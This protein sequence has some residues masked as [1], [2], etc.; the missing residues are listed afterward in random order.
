MII[1]PG[2]RATHLRLAAAERRPGIS[3][4][5]ANRRP[6]RV[7]STTPTIAATTARISSSLLLEGSFS[8]LLRSWPAQAK[9]TTIKTT[10]MRAPARAFTPTA[11]APALASTPDFCRYRT[12]SAI[13]PTLAGETRLINDDAPWASTVG[14]HRI[15]EATAPI[16]ATAL[17][18]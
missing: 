4:P 15:R 18:R 1:L 10:W 2:L 11:A 8:A 3:L 14:H 7:A 12:F 16:R 17:A 13:P 9:N 6:G 5:V